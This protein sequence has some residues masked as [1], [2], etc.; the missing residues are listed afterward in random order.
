MP[1]TGAQAGPL[2]TTPILPPK[3]T[4]MFLNSVRA[5]EPLA[6]TLMLPT[7]L[8][9]DTSDA[10]LVIRTFSEPGTGATATTQEARPRA[11]ATGT[12]R[13][14]DMPHLRNQDWRTTLPRRLAVKL[15]G[16]KR[17]I[18]RCGAQSV[19]R[20]CCVT[21]NRSRS[22]PTIVRSRPS[23]DDA[24]SYAQRARQR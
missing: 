11:N 5:L 15:R 12:I 2:V 6:L 19:V 24:R 4:T 20:P 23:E 8:Q 21:I 16:Q 10:F 13:V 22:P 14:C 18:R 7:G 17:P 9:L 3:P 1:S